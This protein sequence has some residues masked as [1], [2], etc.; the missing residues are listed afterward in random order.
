MSLNVINIIP[1]LCCFIAFCSISIA[2]AIKINSRD[3]IHKK[4]KS[5]IDLERN[6]E[7]DI[8]RGIERDIEIIMQQIKK[9]EK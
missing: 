4:I 3:R 9:K 1:Y 7:R 6:I 8:E 2:L 5:S